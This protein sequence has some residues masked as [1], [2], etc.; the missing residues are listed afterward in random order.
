MIYPRRSLKK[1]YVN[2]GRR[3]ETLHVRT[4][5]VGFAVKTCGLIVKTCAGLVYKRGKLGISCGN[6]GVFVYSGVAFCVA[7]I[8]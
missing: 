8:G 6:A 5:G 7:I 4:R 3:R 2:G 1:V